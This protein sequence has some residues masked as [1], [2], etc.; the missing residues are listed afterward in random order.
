[1]EIERR[2]NEKRFARNFKCIVSQRERME[3]ILYAY[4]YLYKVFDQ[5]YLLSTLKIIHDL[6][7]SCNRTNK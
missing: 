2:E 1:M 7:S 3:D 6:S 5:M 4:H